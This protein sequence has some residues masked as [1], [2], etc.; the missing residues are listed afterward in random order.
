[1]NIFSLHPTLS[2]FIFRMIVASHRLLIAAF[3][4]LT[5]LIPLAARSAPPPFVY[6]VFS[7]DLHSA[8]LLYEIADSG[9]TRNLENIKGLIVSRVG[10]R[11]PALRIRFDPQ[12]LAAY[13][14]NLGGAEEALKQ[15]R[16]QM[17]PRGKRLYERELLAASPSEFPPMQELESI[18]LHSVKG[19]PVRL[20]D[21]ATIE[22]GLEDATGNA[23]YQGKEV[24][25][26]GIVKN[27]EANRLGLLLPLHFALG[28][29]RISLPP[30]VNLE[31]VSP[32]SLT[33][34]NH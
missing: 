21:V 18:V 16:L 15:L 20:S 2:F 22:I 19:A 32:T 11:R 1:M 12:R 8:A 4:A 29:M 30:E 9:S 24:L 33:I 26:L 7:S 23:V 17:Q 6:F 28:Q 5:F 34:V 13:G 14:L 10:G 31:M 27:A 3:F 25:A